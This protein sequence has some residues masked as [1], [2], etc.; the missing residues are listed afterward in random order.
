MQRQQCL[1]PVLEH[2]L[3]ACTGLSGV[4]AKMKGGYVRYFA[5][6]Q[7]AAQLAPDWG[8]DGVLA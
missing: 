7:Q 4:K 2:L 3:V 6:Q 1:A 8:Q 5:A